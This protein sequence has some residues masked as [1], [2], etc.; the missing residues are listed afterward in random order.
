MVLPNGRDGKVSLSR[1][2]V[3][4]LDSGV[5]P[6]LGGGGGGGGMPGTPPAS[7]GRRRQSRAR[8]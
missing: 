3:V 2:A 7:E 5:E 4:L 8:F 6:Q 1:K